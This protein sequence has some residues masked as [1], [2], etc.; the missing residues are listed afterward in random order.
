MHPRFRSCIRV[1]DQKH[2]CVWLLNADYLLSERKAGCVKPTKNIYQEYLSKLVE[3]K[4]ESLPRISIQ[5]S[6]RVWR[7]RVHPSKK[8]REPFCWCLGHV[9][10]QGYNW[11]QA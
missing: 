1:E 6:R 3:R 8:R 10:C 4:V 9:G 2:R 11:L 5:T 7:D